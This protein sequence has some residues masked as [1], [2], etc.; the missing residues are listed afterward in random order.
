MSTPPPEV[1][2][3]PDRDLSRLEVV[4]ATVLR[5]GVGISS[6]VMVVGAAVTL[7][8]PSTERA[9][10]RS[11][12]QLRHGSLHLSGL[13]IPHSVAAVAQGLGHGYGPAIAML[14]LLLLIATPVLRVGVSVVAFVHE[15]DRTFVLITLT[16]LVVLLGSFAVGT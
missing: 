6:A 15:R 8:E 7:L 11:L 1:P 16:V 13:R 12:A 4:V 2:P 10:R 3:H 14:G 9:A 5:L